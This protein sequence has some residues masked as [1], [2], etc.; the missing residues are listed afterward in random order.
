V[1]TYCPNE[2]MTAPMNCPSGTT[3][4]VAAAVC[5]TMIQSKPRVPPRTK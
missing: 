4:N 1:N 3:S 2:G 5:M